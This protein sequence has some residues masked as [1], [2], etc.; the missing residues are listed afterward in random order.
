MNNVE[1]LESELGY[2]V[3]DNLIHLILNGVVLDDRN[4]SLYSIGV[5]E[6]SVFELCL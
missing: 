4:A 6:G 2:E 3:E 1:L 5:K